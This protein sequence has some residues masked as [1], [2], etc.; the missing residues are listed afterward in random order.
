MNVL[1][2]ISPISCIIQNYSLPLPSNP[3]ELVGSGHIDKIGVLCVSLQ[4]SNFAHLTNYSEDYSNRRHVGCIPCLRS[5]KCILTFGE[6]R[7]QQDIHI[8]T[9]ANCAVLS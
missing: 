9:W 7:K 3:S 1:K 4:L 8:Q 5:P 2:K 6:M